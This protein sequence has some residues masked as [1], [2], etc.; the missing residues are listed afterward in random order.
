MADGKGEL[1]WRK[2]RSCASSAC[3]EV[4]RDEVSFLVRDSADPN[5]ARLAFDHAAWSSFVARLS[6][7]SSDLNGVER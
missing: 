1:T 3:V 6:D 7:E 4:A 2:S 5:G